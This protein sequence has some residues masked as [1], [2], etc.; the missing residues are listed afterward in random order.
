VI[1]VLRGGNVA[2]EDACAFRARFPE[3]V[4]ARNALRRL[5]N[6]SPN[7]E[8]CWGFLSANDRT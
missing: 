4:G 1:L 2:P 3:L 7:T 5:R 6:K 8:T